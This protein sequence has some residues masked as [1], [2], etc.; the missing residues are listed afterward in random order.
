[1]VAIHI[2]GAQNYAKMVCQNNSFL[3]AV[4]TISIGDFQYATLNIPF[5]TDSNTNIEHSIN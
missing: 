4:T 2:L 5:F 3:Q 1:M